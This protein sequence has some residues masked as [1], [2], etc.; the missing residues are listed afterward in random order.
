[1]EL[2][3]NILWVFM[4]LGLLGLWRAQWARERRSERR[5]PLCE[6]TAFSCA[7][8]LLFFAVSMTDDLHFDIVLFDECTAGRRHLGYLTCHHQ[9]PQSARISPASSVAILPGSPSF[10]P[11]LF[12]SAIAPVEGVLLLCASDGPS[13]GRSPPAF[14]HL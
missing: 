2:F 12:S 11:E 3:L 5:D 14:V 4:A 7:I 9:E 1:M 8:V 10:S 6:W 13:S